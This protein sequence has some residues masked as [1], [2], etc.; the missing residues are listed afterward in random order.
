MITD[1]RLHIRPQGITQGV[2]P[3]ESPSTYA[4]Q[5]ITQVSYQHRSPST[6][7]TIEQNTS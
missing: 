6:Y 7:A 3:T 2:I 5:G 4:T 1:L